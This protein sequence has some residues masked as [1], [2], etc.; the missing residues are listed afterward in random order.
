[1]LLPRIAPAI[2]SSSTCV[3][4]PAAIMMEG[5]KPM[6]RAIGKGS[7]GFSRDFQ[8]VPTSLHSF[9]LNPRIFLSSLDIRL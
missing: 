6:E 4:T 8:K 1:M 2:K 5:S 9:T 7:S 3:L